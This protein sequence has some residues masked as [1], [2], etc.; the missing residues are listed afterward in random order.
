MRSLLLFPFSGVSQKEVKPTCSR[1]GLCGF[2]FIELMLVAILIGI[3]VGVSTPIFR[4]TFGHLQLDNTTQNL[5][6]L[7][8]FAQM[9][10]V[11]SGRAHRLR[12]DH[13]KG[14][15]WL[16]AQRIKER[17]LLEGRAFEPIKGR[18]GKRHY[19][20]KGV[21]II[22]A[23]EGTTAIIF[24]PDGGADR[25]SLFISDQKEKGYTI[26]MERRIGHVK[27]VEGQEE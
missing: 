15:Y 27:V 3:I 17:P 13:E 2:T 8:R 6:G 10:A 23:K 24:Y 5:T 20:P 19:I 16:E 26:A 22:F 18:P 9:R 25:I 21:S 12:F 1:R 14:V 11:A 4:R 7:M